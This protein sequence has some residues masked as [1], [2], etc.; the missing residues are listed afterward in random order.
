MV[1]EIDKEKEYIEKEGEREDI[2]SA[3]KEQI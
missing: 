3:E 2:E 1:K